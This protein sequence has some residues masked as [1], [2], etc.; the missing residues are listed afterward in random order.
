MTQ[1]RTASW[2]RPGS[3][4]RPR[5][6]RKPFAPAAS[7]GSR[8]S[9]LPSSQP[10]RCR[11]LQ[12]EP[13]GLLSPM[14]GGDVQ[15]DQ[16]GLDVCVSQLLRE[17]GQ[18]TSRLQVPYGVGVP[19]LVGVNALRRDACPPGD[20]LEE[21]ATHIS[22]D[23]SRRSP[24]GQASLRSAFT[25]T[26]SGTPTPYGTWRREVRCPHSLSS[27]DTQTS[28]PRWSTCTSPPG[29]GLKRPNGSTCRRRHL[30]G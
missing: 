28:N 11:R 22:A 20:L 21:S 24:G 10:R 29:I 26:S 23:S 12:V 19:E 17:C 13:L 27:W 5:P 16:R 2:S 1:T 4:R 18:R 30:L 14:P 8:A 6:S 15:V 25:P 7:K 3:V 9:P